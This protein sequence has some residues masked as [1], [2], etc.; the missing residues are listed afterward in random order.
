MSDFSIDKKL[1]IPQPC[2]FISCSPTRGKF[3]QHNNYK[4]I[5]LHHYINK[6]VIASL[7]SENDRGKKMGQTLK[8]FLGQTAASQTTGPLPFY[9][10]CPNLAIPKKKFKEGP[11]FVLFWKK[12][13]KGVSWKGIR[14]NI[15]HMWKSMII[16]WPSLTSF[17]SIQTGLSDLVPFELPSICVLPPIWHLNSSWKKKG[18]KF[19]RSDLSTHSLFS[20]E[21]SYF[22][23][24]NDKG[25]KFPIHKMLKFQIYRNIVFWNVKCLQNDCLP[26]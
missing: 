1:R 5:S 21:I 18:I 14:W 26:K 10:Q 6:P 11:P 7:G 17:F 19:D 9:S 24:E 3:F 8:R 15:L 23:S 16:I 13:W 20:D 12:N 22:S 2:G 25:T 4:N